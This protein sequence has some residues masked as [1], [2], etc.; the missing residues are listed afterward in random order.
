MPPT[1]ESLSEPLSI[2]FKRISAVEA[3]RQ[4]SNQHEFNGT[5]ALQQVLGTEA[6]RNWP[7]RWVFLGDSAEPRI[8]SHS[9]SW[10]D[11][12]ATHPTRSEWRLYFKDEPEFYEGDLL[13]VVRRQSSET[14]LLL[15]LR[16]DS[17]PWWQ[18]EA[19]LGADER[20]LSGFT[21]LELR[22]LQ[23]VYADAFADVLEDSGWMAYPLLGD[24]GDLE[25]LLE[26][27][28]EGFPST[29]EFSR[30]ARARVE[31]AW[32]MSPDERLWS[33]FRKE[34]GLFRALEHH[35]LQERL[36]RSNPFRGVEEFLEFSLSIQNR[37][38]SRA[39]Y[40]LEHHLEA[41]FREEGIRFTRGAQ[42][43]GA[44][45]PDFIL[46]SIEA[47]REH[48]FPADMLSMVG[49]KTSCK[50]RWRQ[51]L[52]EAERVQSKHLLTLEPSI[53]LSQLGEMADA[54]VILVAPEVVLE[55]YAPLPALQ[56]RSVATAIEEFR[57]RQQHV[58][59]RTDGPEQA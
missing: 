36:G 8:E 54:R 28:P 49:V 5:E 32:D 47:Y 40:A 13:V 51:I 33:W 57:A 15:I 21:A 31:N 29:R 58:T 25:R 20:M 19:L 1:R 59:D 50:D 3:A 7:S 37:R 12:R 14:L 34:E 26:E 11:A 9:C 41:L 48:D 39:G 27:F 42:T 46:P 53:S 43:E 23:A 16:A 22:D 17:A 55:T 35:E 30:F 38:K 52:N 45:K 44:R 10:Y 2:A 56:R 18:Y 24:S 6:R 4:R